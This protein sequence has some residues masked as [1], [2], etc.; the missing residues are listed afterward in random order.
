VSYIYYDYKHATWQTPENV[1]SVIIKDI[2]RN[3]PLS[4]DLVEFYN[5]HNK[6][7]VRPT[8]SDLVNILRVEAGKHFCV[9]VV[10]DTID[11]LPDNN[12]AEEV[13]LWVLSDLSPYLN[14]MVTSRPHVDVAKHFPNVTRIKAAAKSEDIRQYAENGLATPHFTSM[15]RGRTALRNQIIERVDSKAE[16]M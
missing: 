16:G 7:H 8:L 3:Q 4:E 13:L 9:F 1:V 2:V 6:A 12:H 15:V 5:R 10:V 11:E 14:I